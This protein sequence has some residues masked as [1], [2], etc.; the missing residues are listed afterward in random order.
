VRPSLVATAAIQELLCGPEF[1]NIGTAGAA[2]GPRVVKVAV[3][4]TEIRLELDKDVEPQSVAA[5]SVTV[6][7]FAGKGA[8]QDVSFTTALAS[9]PPAITLQQL[10]PALPAGSLVRLVVRGTGPKPVLGTNLAPL[11]GAA[12]GPE[13]L[14][15]D[16]LDFVYME[17]RS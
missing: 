13:P 9:G 10:N 14:P 2:A 4:D 1:R 16:G 12:G 15:N 17:K 8:W 3:S 7:T 5:D 11:A 6:T